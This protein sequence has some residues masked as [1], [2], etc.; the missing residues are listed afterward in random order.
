M[1]MGRREQLRYVWHSPSP[2]PSPLKG[3]GV[4]V[5]HV[6]LVLLTASL[7]KGVYFG[8]CGDAS[9]GM[10]SIPVPSPSP[11]AAYAT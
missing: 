5:G 3:E 8:D 6:D 9:N 2:Q 10:I 7:E 11:H 1:Q 4:F